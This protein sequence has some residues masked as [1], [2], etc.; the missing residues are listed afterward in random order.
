M[1]VCWSV[2]F[3][4]TGPGCSPASPCLPSLWGSFWP[5][6][7]RGRQGGGSSL[8]PPASPDVQS[9]QTH[10]CHAHSKHTRRLERTPVPAGTR[11]RTGFRPTW[12][13]V[14]RHAELWPSHLKPPETDPHPPGFGRTPPARFCLRHSEELQQPETLLI[15]FKHEE[16]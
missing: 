1:F 13:P 2:W 15:H 14:Q 7:L 4:L 3:P 5:G 16:D 11:R 9:A 10:P 12:P 6:C 8:C